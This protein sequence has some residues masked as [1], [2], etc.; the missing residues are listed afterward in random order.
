VLAI[1]IVVLALYTQGHNSR[2][3]STFNLTSLTVLI[4]ATAFISFGQEC[5]ILTGGIDLSV[6]P[7]AGL[8]VVIGSFFENA[9][10]AY[11]LVAG[12]LVMIG[13]QRSVLNGSM[14]G[15]PGS[16]PSWPRWSPTALQ[17]VSLR[18][19]RSRRA[20]SLSILNAINHSVGP[21]AIAFPGRWPWRSRWSGRCTGALA[22]APGHRPDP[23]RRVPP[24]GPARHHGVGYVASA[25]FACVGGVPLMAQWEWVT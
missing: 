25:L 7:L 16:R 14:V 13:P 19:A 21:V 12:F 17:G 23:G 5:V 2:F 9:G 4:A 18:C 8:V 6:G 22:G 1:A 24:G 15:S 3:L 11:Y 10:A 20:Y